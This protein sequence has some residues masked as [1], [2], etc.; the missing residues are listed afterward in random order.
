MIESTDSKHL[1]HREPGEIILWKGPIPYGWDAC[2]GTNGTPDLST[3]WVHLDHLLIPDIII[4][5]GN[6]GGRAALLR[7]LPDVH[8]IR[9]TGAQ[10][11]TDI[12]RWSGVSPKTVFIQNNAVTNSIVF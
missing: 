10:F 11:D 1:L 3:N 6:E 12:P 9:K 8:Y 2:D 5:K 7:T 4:S